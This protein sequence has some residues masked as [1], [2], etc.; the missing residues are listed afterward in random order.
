[1][2]EQLLEEIREQAALGGPTAPLA[3]ELLVL[4]DRYMEKEITRADFDAGIIDIAS[5]KAGAQLHKDP[6]KCRWV[7]IAATNLM[8]AIDGN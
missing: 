7:V 5:G 1:M 6:E 2:R 3:N 4:A 8:G